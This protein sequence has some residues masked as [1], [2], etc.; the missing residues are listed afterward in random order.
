METV[1][2]ARARLTVL[3]TITHTERQPFARLGCAAAP[4]LDALIVGTPLDHGRV[5]LVKQ[6]SGVVNGSLH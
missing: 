5:E 6:L 3:S 4:V 1:Y 2:E